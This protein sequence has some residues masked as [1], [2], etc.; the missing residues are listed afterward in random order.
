MHSVRSALMMVASAIV[1]LP[2]PARAQKLDD[3]DRKFLSDVHPIILL[4]EEATFRALKDKAD[5]LEFEKIFWARRDPGALARYAD[6]TTPKNAFQEQYL[7]DLAA[8]DD[9]FHLAYTRGSS[10]DCGRFLILLGKPDETYLGMQAS[11]GLQAWEARG[12]QTR[13]PV[14]WVYRHRPGL[15]LGG[16][17]GRLVIRFDQDCHAGTIAQQLNHIAATKVAHR[18]IGYS[19]GKDGHLVPLAEQLPKATLARLLLSHPRQ[20]FPVAVQPSFLRTADS[21]T[22]LLGLVRGQAA[23]LAVVESGSTKVV[24]VSISADALAEDGTEADRT[25]QTMKAPVGS[26]GAFVGSFKLTL[27][28]GRYTLK[29]GALDV[30]SA[31]GSVATLTVDVPDLNKVETTG[32]STHRV[33]SAA[34]L[35]VREIEDVPAGAP[36]DPADPYAAFSLGTTRLVPHFGTT[37]QRS[38]LLVIFY[39]VYDLGTDRSGR[40]DATAT[41]SI[42]KGTSALATHEDAI[43]TP[44]GGSAVGPVPLPS[45]EPGRYAVRLSLEDKVGHRSEVRELP[46]EVLP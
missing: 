30:A 11:L 36:S 32:G 16:P 29:A 12:V 44:I 13:A 10:S 1:L 23:G 41:V 40:A 19:V 15:D 35:L 38:D 2:A 8:A 9:K 22:A 42:L 34:L 28:P 24:I 26:D 18:E 46:I 43:T 7:K 33:P 14:V 6:P 31:R 17:A 5:R 27:K 20:D 21:R 37:F 39:Q 4:D 25:E 45:L 3:D